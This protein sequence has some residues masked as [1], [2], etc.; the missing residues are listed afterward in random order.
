MSANDALRLSQVMENAQK[1]ASDSGKELDEAA[2]KS[3]LNAATHYIP[4]GSSVTFADSKL[5]FTVPEGYIFIPEGGAKVYYQLTQG[6]R[7]DD[8][9]LKKTIGVVVRGNDVFAE[10]SMFAFVTLNDD[11]HVSDADADSLNSDELAKKIDDNNKDETGP[12]KMTNNVW[13]IKPTYQRDIHSFYFAHGFDVV[14]E[15]Q[16]PQQLLNAS[17][18]MFGRTEMVSVTVVGDADKQ[19]PAMSATAARIVAAMWVPGV[20]DPKWP[21]SM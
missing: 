21:G 13:M 7:A 8:D 3:D 6:T 2:V 18:L 12:V 4:A 20:T 11:G 15:G 5:S 14:A 19:K 9:T 16:P 1:R 10:K 17:L